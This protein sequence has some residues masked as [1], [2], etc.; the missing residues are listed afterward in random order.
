MGG[1]DD[2][3]SD[4]SYPVFAERPVGVPTTS[5][6]KQ[7]IERFYKPGQYEKVNLLACVL[8]LHSYQGDSL[9]SSTG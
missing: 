2:S 8:R 3:R 4:R 1:G 9:V 6:L 7:R 5:I